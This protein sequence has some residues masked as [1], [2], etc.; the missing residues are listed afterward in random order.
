[1]I[2]ILDYGAIGDGKFMNTQAFAAAVEAA[3]ATHATINVPAGVFL[4]AGL[5]NCL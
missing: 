3:K 4:T 1:M 5:I 2:N